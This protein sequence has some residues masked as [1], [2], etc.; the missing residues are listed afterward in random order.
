MQRPVYIFLFVFFVSTV[1]A[2]ESV[3][4]LDYNARQYFQSEQPVNRSANNRAALSLPFVDDF[5]YNSTF[6]DPAKWMVS[7]VYVNADFP[8]HPPSIGVATFDGL[9]ADGR[10]YGQPG[11]YGG[12]DTLL[13]Q[14]IDLASYTIADSIYFSFFYQ[15]QGNGNPPEFRD[16][17]ILEFKKAN[18]K[19]KKAWQGTIIN[20][21]IDSFY[22]KM[23]PVFDT[24][25]FIPDFQFRFRNYASLTGN[26]DHWH[27]DFVILDKD[28]SIVNPLLN[29]VSFYRNGLPLLKNY[30]SMPLKQFIGFEQQ[31][32]ADSLYV[33]S[34]NNFNIVKNTTFSYDAFENCNNSQVNADFFQ[35]INFPPVSDTVLAEQN[36]KNEII[37]LVNSVSCDSLVIA[38]RYFLQNSPP[39]PGTAF[40]DT[41][42]H[43]QRFYNYLAYDDGTAEVAYRLQG[44]GAQF[45]YKFKLNVGDSLRAIRVHFAHIDIDQSSNVIN[46][47]VWKKLDFPS[48]AA[49]EIL[50]RKDLIKPVYTDSVNGF[51]TYL[52]DTVMYVSDSIYVGL[53]QDK[54]DNFRVGMDRNNVSN[55]NLFFY[56]TG[57]WKQS[58]IPG[59]L[60]VR[61]VLGDSLPVGIQNIKPAF[62]SVYPNPVDQMLY[63]DFEQFN[64]NISANVY[65]ITGQMMM[66]KQLTGRQVDVS[67]LPDGLY[68]LHLTD[69]RGQQ[70]ISRFVIM[71]E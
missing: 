60:M 55:Q 36:Y 6:P 18:G 7:G 45:A 30:Y 40:N 15:P 8:I 33:F 61:I 27:I 37:N 20:L 52:L 16:S 2:Q 54:A 65:S 21:Q 71:H 46:L 41:V 19:W 24:F 23:I 25:Y 63:I 32:L 14:E 48:G 67:G 57:S 4:S 59:A 29:D 28:R 42:L 35:T 1:Y 47:I 38:T 53:Q 11:E 5:S 68:L 49:D 3:D 62:I 13:S 31:E 58:T 22:F 51:H 34:N 70:Y 66:Q 56:I 44:K 12:A 50:Y 9:R 43:F 69:D 17:I 26:V 39:D 64:R 10:P